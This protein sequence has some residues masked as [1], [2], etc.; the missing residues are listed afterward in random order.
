MLTTEERDN[1]VKL[2][3]DSYKGCAEKYSDAQSSK[4]LREAL[5]EANNG[6]TKLDYR[7]IRD[8]KCDGVFTL[9]EEILKRT[10]LEGLQESDFFNALVEYR[11]VAAG[12]KTTFILPD[13]TLF[14][15]DEA[16]EG[17]QAIRRQRIGGSEE[18]SIPTSV[19][20]VRIYEEL[21]RI[22]AGRV[23]FNDLINKVSE[24]FQKK[25]LNDVY[26]VFAGISAAQ[27]GGTYYKANGTYDEST[28]LTLIEHVEAAGGGQATIFGTKAA[29][30]HLAPSIISDIN[31]QDIYNQGYYGKFFGAPVVAVPQRHQIGTDTFVL[32]DDIL[33][34]LVGDAGKPIK[35]VR[36]GDPLIITKDP[37]ENNDLTQEYFYAEKYGVGFVLAGNRNPGIGIYD[38]A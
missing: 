5:I 27:I 2:A 16:A 4:A 25:I 8:G 23:D 10:V 20:A 22:L 24:S 36:E 6:S 29:L 37:S 3:V 32:P 38:I 19:K 26:T 15:V 28:L 7:A 14:T 11:D 31:K 13:T 12:D 9:I 30:R 17:T 21:S 18:I 34:I 1:L 35:L 33:T